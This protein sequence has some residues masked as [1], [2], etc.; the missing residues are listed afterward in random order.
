MIKINSKQY[1]V[2]LS[3]L[4]KVKNLKMLKKSAVTVASSYDVDKRIIEKFV[5]RDNTFREF[6]QHYFRIIDDLIG[7]FNNRPVGALLDAPGVGKTRFCEELCF[8]GQ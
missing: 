7:K 6:K 5:G 8:I 4:E 3:V 2:F 1:T